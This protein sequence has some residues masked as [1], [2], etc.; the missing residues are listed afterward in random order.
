MQ[1]GNLTTGVAASGV[2]LLKDAQLKTTRTGSPF[3]ALRLADRT[4]EISGNLWDVTE[5]QVAQFQAGVVVYVAGQVESY[6]DQ[7]QFRIQELRLA[8]PEEGQPEDFVPRVT[9]S[10]Q[11]LKDGLRPF[12]VAIK[13]PE[14]ARIVNR[15]FKKYGT[16]F[17][18][19]P[20]AKVNHHA[21]VGGLA[22]H[23]LSILRLAEYVCD[24]YPT[25]NHELLYAGA[26]LHDMGK[27][28]E[29]SGPVATQYTTAGDL[30]GHIS[31]VDG[32]IVA[33]CQE[34]GLSP[35]NP[36]VLLLRHVILAHHGLRE[37]GSP[38]EP[39]LLE[40]E[41]LHRLDELDAS[42]TEIEGAL[43]Q[44]VPGEY[45]PRLV[46]LDRRHFYRAPE[47]EDTKKE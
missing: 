21:L 33:A 16:P 40:A 2:A 8:S 13:Q 27:V 41:V 46:A 15:L 3:L 36:Q 18:E 7:L 42:I 30:L 12:L 37:Y 1:I 43:K 11:E 32:E 9:Q 5:N 34:E 38:V 10:Q 25:I 19:F 23:T 31:L 28:I 39:E 44:T 24:Q 17:F 29:L 35:V 45:S 47:L 4:G 6:Q 14:W 20:A 22:F 26:L